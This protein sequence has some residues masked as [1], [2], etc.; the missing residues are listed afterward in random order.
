MNTSPRLLV[1]GRSGQVAQ[2][3]AERAALRGVPLL[4]LGRETLDLASFSGLPEAAL[5]FQPTAVINAAAFTA[6]DK[7]EE[8]REEAFAINAHGAGR[9]AEAVRALSVPFL[10]LSTDYVYDGSKA[11]P[12]VETDPTGPL[13]VYGTS[14]LSGEDAVIAAHPQALVFRTA[15]VYSPFGGNFVKTMLRLAATRDRLTVV[16]DQIGSP[17]SAFDIADALLGVARSIGYEGMKGRAGIYHLAGGGETSWCGF[18][19]AI[20]KASAALGG[21]SLEV[22]PITTA[23][24]PTPARRPANSRL[25]CSKLEDA[26]SLTLPP[27]QDS[28]KPIVERLVSEAVADA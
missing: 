24:Y 8:S 22:E 25:D 9:L 11:A 1:I 7:A 21:P 28:L 14:K 2:A 27:W 18:A 15:W 4:A 17:T 3:L 6:V 13:G 16:D 12:Y 20:F 26:F 19:R 5:A 10:H 23:Q